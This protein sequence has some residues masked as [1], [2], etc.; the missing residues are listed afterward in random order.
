MFRCCPCARKS[1]L[2]FVSNHSE[3]VTSVIPLIARAVM[4]SILPEREIEDYNVIQNNGMT[5]SS[6]P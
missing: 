1:L 2:N 6:Y 4:K 3:Q 5:L